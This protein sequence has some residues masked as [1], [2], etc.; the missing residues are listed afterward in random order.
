VAQLFSETTTQRVP[1][2]KSEGSVKDKDILSVFFAPFAL[3]E[4]FEDQDSGNLTLNHFSAELV[5]PP[6]IDTA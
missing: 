6:T 1:L 5:V 4:R 3:P 2:D